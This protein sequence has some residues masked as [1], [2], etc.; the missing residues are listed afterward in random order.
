MGTSLSHTHTHTMS[1]LHNVHPFNPDWGEDGVFV[2]V[3]WGVCLMEAYFWEGDAAGHFINKEGEKT[4]AM[5]TMN[6]EK[7]HQIKWVFV[8]VCG[9]VIR[10]LWVNKMSEIAGRT[11]AALYI[12]RGE[13]HDGIYCSTFSNLQYW[14]ERFKKNSIQNLEDMGCCFELLIFIQNERKCWFLSSTKGVWQ[15]K[16]RS[17]LKFLVWSVVLTLDCWQSTNQISPTA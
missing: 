4:Y 16:G 2:C 7:R 6:T 11:L 15:K 9:G 5:H 14:H 8:C 13:T 1:V 10:G 12:R 3:G 17:W